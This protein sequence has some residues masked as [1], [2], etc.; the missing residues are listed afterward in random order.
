MEYLPAKTTPP[1]EKDGIPALKIYLLMLYT[2]HDEQ[3]ESCKQHGL[4]FNNWVNP[5][6]IEIERVEEILG[7]EMQSSDW[8]P[9]IT[10]MVEWGLIYNPDG[11]YEMDER[12]G[13]I[14]NPYK[15]ANRR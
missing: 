6:A 15:Y 13:I 12:S 5:T 8:E 2:F 4:S 3:F 11:N 14:T 9:V 7:C 1:L 10:I